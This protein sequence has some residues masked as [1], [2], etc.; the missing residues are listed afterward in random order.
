MRGKVLLFVAM[1][2]L[3]S[4]IALISF[5]TVLPR[6]HHLN[7]P[8]RLHMRAD[9]LAH[10]VPMDETL[11]HEA[12][13]DDVA[14]GVEWVGAQVLLTSQTTPSAS[15]VESS[16]RPRRV[17][18][19]RRQVLTPPRREASTTPTPM[20]TPSIANSHQNIL[21]E[22]EYERLR[23]KPGSACFVALVRHTSEGLRRLKRLLGNI[24]ERLPDMAAR[25]PFIAFLEPGASVADAHRVVSPNSIGAGV[26]FVVLPRE[27][28]GEVPSFIVPEH[29]RAWPYPGSSYWGVSYRHMCRFFGVRIMYTPALDEFDYYMRLD[30][31]SFIL[32]APKKVAVVRDTN[33]NALERTE[34]MDLFHEMALARATY[35][36][37]MLHPQTIP[38]FLGD[39]FEAYDRSK[40]LTTGK[41]M[42]VN[43]TFVP[44]VHLGDPFDAPRHLALH[45]WDNFEIVDLRIFRPKH[46][47]KRAAMIRE[48]LEF[49]DRR[50]GFYYHRWGD[51]EMR[52]FLVTRFV[53]QTDIVYFNSF[54][55]Q[56][57]HNYHC[58]ETDV[59][60]ASSGNKGS[61][62]KK[63]V[64]V[65]RQMREVCMAEVA[66]DYGHGSK[67]RGTAPMHPAEARD[68][69]DIFWRH[70][71]GSE[72]HR[73]CKVV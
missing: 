54:G 28:F 6:T 37:V 65:V 41:Y 66:K 13:Q 44:H 9:D 58:P 68:V 26:R 62:K 40:A 73:G 24:K 32:S 72:K 7:S 36:F 61:N 67:G 29:Q 5:Q 30:T 1:I 15:L 60:D 49:M 71:A 34:D 43:G 25:Y 50:G 57:Y 53:P 3:A 45:Y 31:D 69:N 51:A 56:H 47:E 55:Y 19:V 16:M 39:L 64:E 46:G 17:D 21:S 63:R 23:P 35:G 12:E 14:E 33:G 8:H 52:T 27:D 10:V 20:S 22:E 11:M 48:F 38:Q 4:I 42:E 59:V 70:Q 2:L 18:D